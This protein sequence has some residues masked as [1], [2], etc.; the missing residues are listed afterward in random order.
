MPYGGRIDTVLNWLDGSD[1]DRAD[2]VTLYFSKV[3][4]EG[5][6]GGALG[7][8]VKYIHNFTIQ[9]LHNFTI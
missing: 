6:E 8:Q 9:R 1:G 3:D 5:H 4:H 7:H 2:F